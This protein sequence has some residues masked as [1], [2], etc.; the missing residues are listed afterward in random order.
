MRMLATEEMTTVCGGRSLP[1]DMGGRYDINDLPPT[2]VSPGGGPGYI[3]DR[4][5]ALQEKLGQPVLSD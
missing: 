4:W 3:H 1:P 2:L 5:K